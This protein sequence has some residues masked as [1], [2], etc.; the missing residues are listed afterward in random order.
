M[1]RL[2]HDR[3]LIS[4]PDVA[5]EI[6]NT[7]PG[8]LAWGAIAHEVRAEPGG[9]RANARWDFASGSRQSELAR[10]PCPRRRGRWFAAQE[11]RRLAGDPHHPVPDVVTP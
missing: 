10:R 9:Y 7:A 8:I 1:Q 11:G 3:G 2:R 4:I 5:N 6:F